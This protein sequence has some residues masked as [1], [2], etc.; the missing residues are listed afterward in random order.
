MPRKARI[1]VANYPHHIVQRGH[2]RNVV[3]VSDEDYLFYLDNLK[4]WKVKLGV[5]LY[6]WCL[7]TN[8]IHLI[9]EPGDDASSVSELMKRIAGRQTAFVNKQE[10]RTGSLWEGRFKASPIQRDNYLLACCRYVE[11]NPVRANMVSG[12]RQYKWSSYRERLGLSASNMLDFDSSY[13]NLAEDEETRVERYTRYLKQGAS[14]KELALL[15]SACSR[16]QLTG[17]ERFV[18]EI[19]LR[20]GYRIAHRG[21]G[22]PRD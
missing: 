11:M 1:L 18:D 17:N 5:Q 3:F 14:D 20:I 2:N 4:E 12:P 7:M 8:H 19:E 16:N 6:A 15:R 9:V 22:N 21:R 10:N 13:L